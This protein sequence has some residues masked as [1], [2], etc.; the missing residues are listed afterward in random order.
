MCK[1]MKTKENQYNVFNDKTL[2]IRQKRLNLHNVTKENG[3]RMREN[4]GYEYKE[5][6]IGT[7]ETTGEH[8]D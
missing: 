8:N 7:N 3:Q 5:Q 6:T 4:T 2:E 1:R